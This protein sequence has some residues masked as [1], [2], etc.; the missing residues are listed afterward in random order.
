[1]R[2]DQPSITA[3]N[4]AAVRALESMRPA[5]ERLCQDPYARYFVSDS[6]RGPPDLYPALA[7]QIADWDKKF[8]GVCD[9][10][11]VRTRFVDDCLEAA[12]AGGLQQLIILGAGY[13]TRALRF[14][15]L[16]KNVA[17]FE[18]DHPA[19][20]KMKLHRC[21][22][23]RAAF[24]ERMAFVP[25]HFEQENLGQ[26]LFDHGYDR[27]RKSFFIWEGMSYYLSAAAVDDILAF[28]SRHAAQGSVIAFDYLPPT[29]VGG[30]SR[31]TEAAALGTALKHLGEAFV[32]GIDPAT[33]KDFLG[34]RG[35][36]LERNVTASEY[37]RMYL[38]EA[39]WL[40]RPSEMFFFAHARL[41]PEGSLQP[42]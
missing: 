29:V 35:F 16:K 38:T 24:P 3:E 19:T 37:K 23:I 12:L 1:M 9:A 6:L 31:L 17:V 8:P 30:S 21:R 26:K 14:D 4:N 28:I 13:D 33:I 18:L 2:T 42:D 5:E 40:R 39:H 25:I 15:R 11:A 34:K 32:F 41:K 22:H 10:I 27:T 7:A 20:Q 36:A